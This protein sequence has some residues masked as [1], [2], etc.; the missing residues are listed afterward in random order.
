MKQLSARGNLQKIEKL[1]DTFYDVCHERGIT[2]A[3][4]WR[5]DEAAR[6]AVF[7][8]PN[9]NELSDDLWEMPTRGASAT[10][11]S[12]WR[13]LQATP[14][15]VERYHTPTNLWDISDFCRAAYD[16]GYGALQALKSRKVMI[17]QTPA[18]DGNEHARLTSM[19]AD[20]NARIDDER[21][22]QVRAFY[23]NDDSL[24]YRVNPPVR[25]YPPAECPLNERL[26][27]QR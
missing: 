19:Q 2:I 25:Y 22:R 18:S 21:E 17:V 3:T 10:I 4:D 20:I 8:I 14:S 9:D 15:Y 5:Y 1:I 26:S 16:A 27:W 23:G 6:L 12:A 13:A 24:D 7:S 11:E